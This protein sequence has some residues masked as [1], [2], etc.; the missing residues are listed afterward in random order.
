MPVNT[1]TQPATKPML[2]RLAPRGIIRRPVRQHVRLAP[3]VHLPQAKATPPVRFARKVHTAPQQVNLLVRSVLPVH[4]LTQQETKQM[5]VH[6]A[7][8][9]II[10]QQVPQH[11]RFV[12]PVITTTAKVTQVA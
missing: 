7:Q 8:K 9:V 5:L 12:R 4:I 3:K 1:L 11:V 2:V 6:S 10:P